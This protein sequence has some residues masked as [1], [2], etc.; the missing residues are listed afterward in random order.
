MSEN[1]YEILGISI[2]SGDSEITIA[3]R[4]KKQQFRTDSARL[5]LI[6]KAYATLANPTA[7]KRYRQS[8]S[9][10]SN[11]QLEGETGESE[12]SIPSQPINQVIPSSEKSD[13]Q[14]IDNL[15]SKRRQHTILY[16]P[17]NPPEKQT[18]NPSGG[19]RTGTG[20]KKPN[21]IQISDTQTDKPNKTVFYENSQLEVDTV[22]PKEG[23]SEQANKR[24]KTDIITPEIPKINSNNHQINHPEL[25]PTP[26]GQNDERT[27]IKHPPAEEVP[28]FHQPAPISVVLEISYHNEHSTVPLK[29]GC[30][31]VGRP[32]TNGEQ[33]DVPLPD[34]EKFISRKHAFIN[35]DGDNLTIIDNG[36]KNGTLLN[37][38]LL[39]AGKIYPLMENDVLSI[40]GRILRVSVQHIP[41]K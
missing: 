16:D 9:A 14:S 28:I 31:I 40:E 21:G 8:L 5:N 41:E 15:N 1:Y 7:R 3:Y 11:S 18:P 38:N 33:P 6:E 23:T 13:W 36:A 25:E 30:N 22:A 17:E 26:T 39:E 19:Q 35:W 12:Q 20:E 10:Q 4:Q 34:P 37:N 2:N 29:P 32:P 24:Q 27:R